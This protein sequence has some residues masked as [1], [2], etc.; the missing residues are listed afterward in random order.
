MKVKYSHPRGRIEKEVLA[1]KDLRRL[2]CVLH[3]TLDCAFDNFSICK[4]S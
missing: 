3:N 2:G 4:L 1:S